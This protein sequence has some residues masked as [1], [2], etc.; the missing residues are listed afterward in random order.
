ML[1]NVVRCV[2]VWRKIKRTETCCFSSYSFARLAINKQKR[3]DGK[4][5]LQCEG[6]GRQA[7]SRTAGQRLPALGHAQVLLLEVRG[8]ADEMRALGGGQEREWGVERWRG[9]ESSTW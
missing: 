6:T 5:R 4:V 7:P 8:W 9:L 1:A 2:L 3:N